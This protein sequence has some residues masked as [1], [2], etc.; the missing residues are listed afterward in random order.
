MFARSDRGRVVGVDAE[1]ALLV[2]VAV[3]H[4]DD[5][6][7]HADVHHDDVE[8]EQADAEVG[9]GDDVEAAGA[10]GEGLEEAGQ[11]A[12]AGVEGCD[13]GVADLVRSGCLLAWGFGESRRRAGESYVEDFVGDPVDAVEDDEDGEQ[14]PGVCGGEESRVAAAGVVEKEA[15]GVFVG[16]EGGGGGEEAVEGPED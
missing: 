14:P 15:E 9:N 6:R 2:D 13:C 11:G 8:D 4:R 7:V 16:G 12:G 3:A 10:D 5:D 1:G